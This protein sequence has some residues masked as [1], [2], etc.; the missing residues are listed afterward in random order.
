LL[1]LLSLQQ[2]PHLRACG[3]DA[4]LVLALLLKR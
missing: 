2:W 3:M 1:L 4:L